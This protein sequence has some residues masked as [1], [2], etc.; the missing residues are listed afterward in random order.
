[1]S[2]EMTTVAI[3]VKNLESIQKLK[4]HERVPN[5]EIIDRLLLFWNRYKDVVKEK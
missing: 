2:E 1:M 4:E 3:S 5:D